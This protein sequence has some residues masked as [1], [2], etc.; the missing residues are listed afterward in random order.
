[1]CNTKKPWILP[2]LAGA[3]CL[4]S[5]SGITQVLPVTAQVTTPQGALSPNDPAAKLDPSLLNVPSIVPPAP[6]STPTTNS[7]AAA[8]NQAVGHD[9]ATGTTQLIPES[10]APT[11]TSTSPSYGGRAPLGSENSSGGPVTN[12]VIGADNRILVSNTAIYPWRAQAKLYVTFPNGKI[13]GCSGTLIQTKYLLT[14][15]HCVYSKADGGWYKKLEAIPGL[16]GT[17]KPYGSA[18]GKYVRSYQGWTKSQSP[19]HDLAL[20]TLDKTIG[21]TTGYFGYGYYPTINGVTAY[22]SGYPY[23]KYPGG[24]KQYYHYGPITSSTT[25]R[26]YYP[27]DTYD[28]Q[29]G[30]GVYRIISGKRY[31]FAVHGYGGSTSNSGT[32]INSTKFNNIK[33][34]IASGT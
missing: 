7:A 9:S 28:G 23:D 30:S 29:S 15:G 11:T 6:T 33:A 17:Y 14:A 13:Y 26:V 27:I 20:V 10:S 24:T 32:R 5:L 34:W 2:L 4:L 21:S 22:I 31:V 19:D 16:N 3:S 25:Y 8:L 18:Y 12:S 1:M